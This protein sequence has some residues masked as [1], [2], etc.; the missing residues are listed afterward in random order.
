MNLS[1]LVETTHSHLR[2]QWFTRHALR[3]AEERDGWIFRDSTG[4]KGTVATWARENLEAG[5]SPVYQYLQKIETTP[6]SEPNLYRAYLPECT[7]VIQAVGYTPNPIPR[8]TVR[9]H[10]V[11]TLKHLDST[12]GFADE[13]GTTIDGLYGAGIAWPERVVDP[14]G[15]VEYAVGLAKFMRYLKR[16]VPGW[17]GVRESVDMRTG[18]S[19][20]F[21]LDRKMVKSGV[22]TDIGHL[23]AG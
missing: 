5:D 13:H 19:L 21:G 23:M 14:E 2:I 10:P 20:H 9:G 15:N 4:L 3:Y 6:E 1:R 22:S 7:H 16:V 11:S 12:G 17:A 18:G 8:L